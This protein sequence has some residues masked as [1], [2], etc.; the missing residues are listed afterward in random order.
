MTKEELRKVGR[1]ARRALTEEEKQKKNE[2]IR[3]AVAEELRKYQAVM[4]YVPSDGE[5]DLLP[6]F[7]ERM[8]AYP[9]V[10]R[11]GELE[12]LVPAQW[13]RGPFGIPEPSDGWIVDPEEL[14]LVL[15]PLTAFDDEN[16]RLGRGGG[17]YD[18]YLR[19]CVNAR[20][21][22]VAFGE[23]RVEHIET[24]AHDIRLDAVIWA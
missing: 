6:L 4:S 2:K 15:V 23:Q 16:N 8:V 17:Y 24:E 1:A 5:P 20:K 3:R 9:R 13:A 11:D 10:G 12:A 14:E 7:M 21:V 18:R 22:G 19:K